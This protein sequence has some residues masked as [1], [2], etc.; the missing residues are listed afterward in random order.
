MTLKR[1]EQQNGNDTSQAETYSNSA[2]PYGDINKG[3]TG[4]RKK[5]DDSGGQVMSPLFFLPYVASL[6]MSQTG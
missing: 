6:F 2:N 5:G 3:A 1:V 4:E